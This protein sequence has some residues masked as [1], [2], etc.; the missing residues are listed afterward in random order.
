[1]VPKSLAD[2]GAIQGVVRVDVAPCGQRAGRVC[3]KLD[4]QRLFRRFVP[5]GADKSGL[6]WWIRVSRHWS[7]YIKPMFGAGTAAALDPVRATDGND[8]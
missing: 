4:H 3:A 6:R 2:A 1:M 7:F 8:V 5:A